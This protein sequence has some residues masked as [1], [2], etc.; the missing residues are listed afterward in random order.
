M[1]IRSLPMRVPCCFRFLPQGGSWHE[2]AKP[3]KPANQVFPSAFVKCEQLAKLESRFL[4]QVGEEKPRPHLQDVEHLWV[5]KGHQRR[6]AEGF[7]GSHS[8]GNR[9]EGRGG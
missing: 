8:E 7:C 6:E 4:I 9:L 1:Q 2:M 5:S 3:A